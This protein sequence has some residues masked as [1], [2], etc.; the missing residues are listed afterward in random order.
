MVVDASTSLARSV[1]QLSKEEGAEE[2]VGISIEGF[3]VAEE[4]GRLSIP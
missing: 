4:A 3:H 1:G 2:G